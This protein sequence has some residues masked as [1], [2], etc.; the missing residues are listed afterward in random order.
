[1]SDGRVKTSV[2]HAGKFCKLWVIATR[3]KNQVF[4]FAVLS[5]LVSIFVLPSI[6]PSV[7][8]SVCRAPPLALC[9]VVRVALGIVVPF[10]MLSLIFNVVGCLVQEAPAASHL[11]AHLM[12][13]LALDWRLATGNASCPYLYRMLT[14]PVQDHFALSRYEESSF[15]SLT[16]LPVRLDDVKVLNS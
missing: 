3:I 11:C 8:S 16:T 5:C 13:E 2:S 15:L 12:L 6:M 7:A 1:M 9:Q 4:I 10:G 14:N